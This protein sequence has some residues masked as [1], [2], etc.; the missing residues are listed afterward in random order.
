MAP[1][2]L[3]GP[4]L[5]RRAP[6]NGRRGM[7]GAVA[8]GTGVSGAVAG[9]IGLPTT[10][11]STPTPPPTL[12]RTRTLTA[13]AAPGAAATP[14]LPRTPCPRTPLPRR[15]STAAAPTS[16]PPRSTHPPPPH[17]HRTRQQPPPQA[18][19]PAQRLRQGPSP[20]SDRRRAQARMLPRMSTGACSLSRCRPSGT[21]AAL[22]AAVASVPGGWAAAGPEGLAA[23]TREGL[24]AV[25]ARQGWAALGWA[26]PGQTQI[27]SAPASP[28]SPAPP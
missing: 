4:T 19:R 6:S 12:A 7:G 2:W 11:W 24:L 17:T 14:G 10:T 9:W 22:P 25:A 18:I 13:A 26:A 16:P 5:P 1:P 27:R 3:A 15:C 8:G 28:G 23:L 20:G 21:L